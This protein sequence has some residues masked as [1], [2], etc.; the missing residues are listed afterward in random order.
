MGT[1]E[2]TLRGSTEQGNGLFRVIHH[3]FMQLWRY[4]SSGE[5]QSWNDAKAFVKKLNTNGRHR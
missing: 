5:G 3:S 2:V 1:T 4:L